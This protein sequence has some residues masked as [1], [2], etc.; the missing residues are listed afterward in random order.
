MVTSH[1]LTRPLT[2]KFTHSLN[3]SLTHSPTPSSPQICDV[4][5]AKIMKKLVKT[6]QVFVINNCGHALSVEKPGK[7]AQL[8]ERFITQQ[9]Q[10]KIKQ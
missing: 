3:H 10:L 9:L 4:S 5:G 2:H 6:A 1:P 7:C 8:I